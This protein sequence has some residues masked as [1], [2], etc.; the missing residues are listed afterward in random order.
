MPKIALTLEYDGAAYYGFQRQKEQNSVQ[1]ELEKALTTVLRQKTRVWCAG[2]TDTGVNALGQVVHFVAD[3]APELDRLIYALNSLLP[4]DIAIRHGAAVPDDFHARFSCLGREYVYLI[5]NAPYRPGTLGY[6]ALWL[7]EKLEWDRVRDAVPHL[8]GEKNFAA[9]TRAA[10][11]KSGERT[12]R[13]IDGIDVLEDGRY[14]YIHIRGSGFLHNMIR[15][16]VG[17]LLDV[18]RGEMAPEKVGEI[19]ASA[20]RLEAGVT[21][22]PHALYFLQADYRDYDQST[23]QHALRRRIQELKSL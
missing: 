20:D 11:V 3:D 2:R 8:V 18:A 5:Y 15:I 12:H 10:L 16:L 14:I 4:R 17:T 13:R 19:I 22:K 7:R 1:A 6:K 9:F 23:A 21:L